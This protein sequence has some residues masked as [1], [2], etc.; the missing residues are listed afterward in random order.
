[1]AI[2]SALNSLLSTARQHGLVVD[3]QSGFVALIVAPAAGV[4]DGV[5]LI[6]IPKQDD[7]RTLGSDHHPELG[8]VRFSSDLA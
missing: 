7:E 5:L 6:G 2:L 4:L 1:M 3:E 8:A